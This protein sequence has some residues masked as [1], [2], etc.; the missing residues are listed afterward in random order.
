MSTFISM[1][2]LLLLVL[3]TSAAAQQT[4][5][6]AS[7]KTT[8]SAQANTDKEQPSY[9][10]EAPAKLGTIR[11][12]DL[13]NTYEAR[14][15]NSTLR[16]DIPLQDLAR[17]VQVINTELLEDQGIF[18]FDNIYKNITGVSQFSYNLDFQMRGFRTG[19]EQV[20]FNGLRANPYNGLINPIMANVDRVEVLKGPAAILYG[21]GGPGGV[22]NIVTKK[23]LSRSHQ[24]FAL[25]IG[26]W[27]LFRVVA[28][29]T[30][31]IDED[32]DFLYRFIAAYNDAD[33]FRDHVHNRNIQIAPSLTWIASPRTALT[34][35]TVYFDV[36]SNGKRDR[37]IAAPGGDTSVLPISRSFHEPTD[38]QTNDGLAMD[39]RLDHMLTAN[40]D[41]LVAARSTISDYTDQYHE[42]QFFLADGR[43]I[44]RQWRDYFYQID[45]QSLFADLSGTVYWGDVRHTLNVG[46]DY[47][48]YER[49]NRY[50]STYDDVPT[51]DI[52]DPVYGADSSTYVYDYTYSRDEHSSTGLYFRDLISLGQWNF[53]GAIRYSDYQTEEDEQPANT[54]TAMSYEAGVVYEASQALSWYASVA[55]TFEPQLGYTAMEG[56]PFDPLLSTQAEVG[57]KYGLMGGALNVTFALYRIVKENNLVNDPND[58][59]RLLQIGE[60]TSEG[61]E[62]AIAGELNDHW[63]IW[64]GYAYNHARVTEDTNPDNIGKSAPNAP[65]RMWNIWTR[66]DIPQTAFGVAGGANYV[67]ERETFN[68]SVVLPEYTV[69][70]LAFFYQPNKHW[71]LALN[72]NNITDERHFVGGYDEIIIFPGEPRNWQLTLR[73]DF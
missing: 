4:A 13:G 19:R 71:E 6:P 63:R 45:E 23:P 65:R 10:E 73:Y 21:T 44:R 7:D 43:T 33:S 29:S 9:L 53:M 61:A 17:S 8:A 38:L 14:S 41:L 47:A 3:A 39:L 59:D 37:G 12:E 72:L 70:D 16:G 48:H 60:F 52:Y 40:W 69:F 67:S 55:D 26:S 11:V 30:G 35:S 1:S 56:G 24:E 2:G 54:E 18:R 20:L 64:G 46:L 27:N 49:N 28:D 36:E 34:F 51:I 32:G 62:L 42:P 5:N 68:E 25:T 31:P 50:G 66:Y 15:A 22:I 58:P 57:A